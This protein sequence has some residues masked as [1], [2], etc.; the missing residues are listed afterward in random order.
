M[1]RQSTIDKLPQELRDLFNRLVRDGF[2]IVQITEKLN[3]L[4]ADVTQS[5]I[6]RS[7]KAAREQ[8]SVFKQ[9][10][11]VAGVWV[12]D[13]SDDPKGD[14]GVLC[15]QLLTS[16][17]FQ[18]LNTMAQENQKTLAAGKDL[19]PAKPMDLMLLA[20]TVK[21]LE[22]T[23]KQSIERREKIERKVLERQA[24]AAEGAAIKAGATPEQYA[25]IR[26]AFL[27]IPLESKA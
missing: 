11:E 10:Q 9:A 15:A 21:D 8:L 4:D 19:K 14:V 27:G 18:T 3:E 17:S 25:I 12:Q 5:A 13:L 6:G 24:K 16:L 22:A 23:T 2:T 20:K 26:A 7:V 1:G